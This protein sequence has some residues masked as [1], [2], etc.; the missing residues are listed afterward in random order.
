MLDMSILRPILSDG[1]A[2]V[3]SISLGVPG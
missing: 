3:A 2:H 1:A